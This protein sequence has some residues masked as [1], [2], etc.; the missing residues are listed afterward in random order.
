MSKFLYIAS[1]IVLAT[2]C[3]KVKKTKRKLTGEWTVLSYQ[4]TNINGLSY[5]YEPSV[6]NF[7]FGNCPE[8]Q[9]D[10]S[11]FMQYENQGSTVEFNQSGYYEFVE[12]NG[13]YFE[14]YRDNGIGGVD[15]L[16]KAR[17][18]LITKD[19]LKAEFGDGNGR[20]VFIM[21]K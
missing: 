8:K 5:F 13:E 11:F 19:D 21:Q 1:I 3:S 15:T 12:N 9:C 10:Y 14:L 18:I 4:F 17:I 2:A 16:H 6:S 20:H 7:Q